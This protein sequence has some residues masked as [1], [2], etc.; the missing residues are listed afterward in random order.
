MMDE[1]TVRSH[2]QAWESGC[3]DT[4][5][6]RLYRDRVAHLT[7]EQKE[8]LSTWL[9][10]NVCLNVGE[11]LQYM[12]KSYCVFLSRSQMCR[13]LREPGFM[14]KKSREMCP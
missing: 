10:E 13:L 3:V 7:Q 5:K 1:K 11:I 8:K 14:Y 12:G 9:D 4:L 6:Q 2:F